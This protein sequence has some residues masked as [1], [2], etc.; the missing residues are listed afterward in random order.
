[1]KARPL[2]GKTIRKV[3]QQRVQGNTGPAW[4]LEQIDFTDGSCLRFLVIETEG[5]GEYGIEG[6]YYP[7]RVQGTTTVQGTQGTGGTQP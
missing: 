3:H 6:L 7:K 2:H 5:G 4:S 1:M